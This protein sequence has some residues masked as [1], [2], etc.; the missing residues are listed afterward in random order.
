MALMIGLNKFSLVDG[1]V[2]GI[3]KPGFKTFL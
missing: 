1:L 3:G 2:Q